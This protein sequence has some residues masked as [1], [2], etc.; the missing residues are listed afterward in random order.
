MVSRLKN[1]P[2]TLV[3]IS[4]SCV[5]VHFFLSDEVRSY[6]Q[7]LKAV[8]GRRKVKK[9]WSRTYGENTVTFC[10]RLRTLACPARRLVSEISRAS[11]TKH[12]MV[13]KMLFTAELSAVFK[14]K[15]FGKC[16]IKFDVNIS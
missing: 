12:T 7:T 2:L 11:I 1:G 4:I 15:L 13:I 8:H 5:S 16:K 9:H 14:C 3:F 6:D 10:D